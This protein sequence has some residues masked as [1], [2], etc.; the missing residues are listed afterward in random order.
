MESWKCGHGS[1]PRRASSPRRCVAYSR[2]DHR[3]AR[4]GVA[5]HGTGAGGHV[6]A[7]FN[8]GYRNRVAG[9]HVAAGADGGAVLVH[10]VIVG[11]NGAADVGVVAERASPT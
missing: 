1:A 7:H 10:A 3:V 8:R 6:V 2:V 5:H 11:G 9:T 4:H